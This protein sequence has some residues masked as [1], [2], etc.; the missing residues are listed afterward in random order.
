[1]NGLAPSCKS[2]RTKAK[3]KMSTFKK[4]V[5][6]GIGLIVVG[7][8]VCSLTGITAVENDKKQREAERA[9]YWEKFYKEKEQTKHVDVTV[10]VIP[11]E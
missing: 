4:F 2:E 10:H 9:R 7:K 3:A 5:L 6:W 11:V 8:I 1:M